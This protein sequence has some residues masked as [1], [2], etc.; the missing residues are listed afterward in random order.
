MNINYWLA[1]WINIY[2]YLFETAPQDTVFLSFEELCRE[3]HQTISMLLSKAIIAKDD[4]SIQ[5]EIRQPKIKHDD[6]IEP[7]L[8]EIALQLYRKLAERK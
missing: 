3:P 2:R 6:N 1:L 7:A 5:E 4:F 8:R